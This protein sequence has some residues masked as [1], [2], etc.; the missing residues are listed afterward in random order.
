MKKRSKFWKKI[1]LYSLGLKAGS[2]VVVDGFRDQLDELESLASE[3]YVHGIYPL[4]KLSLSQ[5]SLEYINRRKSP[6]DLKPKH[7]LALLNGVDAWISIFGWT[8]R[9]RKTIGYPPEYQPSGVVLEKMAKK[10]VKFALIMLPPRKELPIATVVREALNC[11]YSS[12]HRLGRKLQNALRDSEN[13]TLKPKLAV[14]CSSRL[15]TEPSWL[16]TA[17]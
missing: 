12:M 14:S 7:L 4:L 13:V 1:L 10:K 3:C 16:K 17:C 6:K 15:R 11:S 5:K 9:K 2:C 8:P